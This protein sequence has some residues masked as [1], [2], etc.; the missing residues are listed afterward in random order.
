MNREQES[1][2]VSHRRGLGWRRLSSSGSG[3]RSV[4]P[5]NVEGLA[6]C[7]QLYHINSG[8]HRKTVR[9]AEALNYLLL[10]CFLKIVM[11]SARLLFL[12]DVLDESLKLQHPSRDLS[13]G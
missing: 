3:L 10:L 13:G 6:G 2:L 8:R 12:H 1:F 11:F 9:S 5:R 4:M 7:L